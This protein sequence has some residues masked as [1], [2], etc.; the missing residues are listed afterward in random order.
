[1]FCNENPKILKHK[2]S[3]KQT[4]LAQENVCPDQIMLNHRRKTMFW[5]SKHFLLTSHIFYFN[6]QKFL[7]Q[8]FFFNNTKTD[9]QIK[10]TFLVSIYT[11]S[12]S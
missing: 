7:V 4:F 1:M 2:K 9:H 3:S 10:S 6:F 8:L 5:F 11:F 12:L